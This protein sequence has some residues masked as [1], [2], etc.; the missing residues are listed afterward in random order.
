MQ[1]DSND[2]L[3]V[4]FRLVIIMWE[5]PQL[6][7]KAVKRV[8]VINS[9]VAD[10]NHFDSVQSLWGMDT[11]SRGRGLCAASRIHLFMFV[12][13][14]L[15]YIYITII[16]ITDIIIMDMVLT[17]SDRSVTVYDIDPFTC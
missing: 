5:P 6:Q 7:T 9:A 10:R 15:T 11:L 2:V 4:V 1:N 14:L 8:Q 3:Y 12:S 13:S 17:K 16:F